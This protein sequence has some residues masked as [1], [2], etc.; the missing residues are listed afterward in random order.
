MNEAKLAAFGTIGAI[1]AAVMS[2]LG[3]WDIALQTLLGF[4]AADYLT[5]LVVAG[6]FH[7]SP[8]TAGGSISS[9]AG[10]QGLFKKGGMLLL[11]YLACR[12]D[13]LTATN[14]FRDCCVFALIAN[15]LFSILENLGLMGVPMPKI[16]MKAIDLLK[17]KGEN[18]A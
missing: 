9:S 16:M 4:M 3:G 5:G 2:L 13:M 11:V 10:L 12:I 8:K 1:G 17:S 18:E 6:V 7:K 15:E 14:Y